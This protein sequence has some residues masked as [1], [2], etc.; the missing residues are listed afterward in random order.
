[1]QASIKTLFLFVCMA[2]A[3]AR[4]AQQPLVE[5]P[6]DATSGLP[7]V[8]AAIGGGASLKLV[9]DSGGFGDVALAPA[10]LSTLPVDFNGRSY[11]WRDFQNHRFVSRAFT[12][13]DFRV[14]GIPLG[15]VS[16][17]ELSNGFGGLSAG[18][19]GYLG[20]GLLGKFIVKLD[21]KAGVMSLYQAHGRDAAQAICG[22]KVLAATFRDGVVQVPVRTDAGELLFQVD[23]G[24]SRTFLR[25]GALGLKPGPDGTFAE[26]MRSFSRFEVGGRDLGRQVLEFRDFK[27]PAVDGVLGSDFFHGRTLC[28]D[29]ADEL[30]AFD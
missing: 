6:M 5:V 4:A 21:Y 2:A 22:A 1:M 10:A 30:V 15:A 29:L 18:T 3:A 16:G 25:P 9:V 28:L 8:A 27:A 12:A 20:V 23:T 19:A 24:S 7:V 11:E 14:G 13:D 17:S 26:T